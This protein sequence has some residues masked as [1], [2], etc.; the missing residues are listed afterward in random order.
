MCAV[1]K[2]HGGIT[3]ETGASSQWLGL[4]KYGSFFGRSGRSQAP[5]S[6]T[7][8]P[9]SGGGGTPFKV[10]G[11]RQNDAGAGKHSLQDAFANMR[12]V[13]LHAHFALR[14]C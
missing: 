3:N 2:D 13:L 5:L 1:Q 12:M 8:V 14:F 9:L 7:Q 6:G 10:T 4:S 11:P